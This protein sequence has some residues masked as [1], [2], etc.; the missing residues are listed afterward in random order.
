MTEADAERLLARRRLPDAFE[1]WQ[2]ALAPGEARP[3]SAAEWAG[4]IVLVEQGRIEVECLAGGSRSFVAGDMLSLGWLP[5]R[6]LSNPGSERA[7]LVAVRRRGPKP[8]DRYLHVR[9][10]TRLGCQP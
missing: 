7:L 1:R 4:A 8:T 9:R 2:L 5:L 10:R 6:Q 3:T